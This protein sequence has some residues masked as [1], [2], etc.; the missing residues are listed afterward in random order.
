MPIIVSNVLNPS[1]TNAV[2]RKA[3]TVLKLLRLKYINQGVFLKMDEAT[4][5][6]LTLV[7]P[8]ITWG[9]PNLKTVRELI[10]KRGKGRG[11]GEGVQ[12]ITDN[13]VVEKALGK[14]TRVLL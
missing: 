10:Y 13:R 7:E 5:R 1:S 14:S 6:L 4:M 2:P 12:S 11:K 8:Y 9:N 3:E